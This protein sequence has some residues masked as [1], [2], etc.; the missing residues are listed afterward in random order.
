LVL[1]VKCGSGAFMKNL[2]QARQLASTMVDLGHDHGV[3]TSAVV[4]D[5]STPLGLTAGNALE[6]RESIE[7]LAGGGPA[8]VVELTVVLA[9][10]MLDG[11]ADTVERLGVPAAGL[12]ASD[13]A[14]KNLADSLRSA[15]P[16]QA[17]RDGRAM[18]TWKAMIRAQGG[19]PDAALPTAQ[20]H[21]VITAES[22]GVM[23]SLDALKVGVAAWRL[24]AGRARKEDLVQAGAGVELHTKP[25]D[26]VSLGQPIMTLHTD[27]PAAF[28]AAKEALVGAWAIGSDL[29]QQP[30]LVLD[31][32]TKRT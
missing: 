3:A 28:P 9:R 17:L 32:L 14:A 2:D 15:D 7:V 31:R 21:E 24:G 27:T 1:D 26:Q 12:S 29:K 4:T 16:A 19:D 5:M 20:H 11:A 8:D 22:S 10:A 23:T 25:G 30:A 6:V 18:D 13:K